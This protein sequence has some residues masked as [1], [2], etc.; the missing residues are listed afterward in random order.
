MLVPEQSGAQNYTAARNSFVRR[1]LFERP[2]AVF[3]D[4]AVNFGHEADS[5]GERGDDLLNFFVNFAPLYRLVV[6][7]TAA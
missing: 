1:L 2:A 6:E 4:L 5:F 7:S 3:F